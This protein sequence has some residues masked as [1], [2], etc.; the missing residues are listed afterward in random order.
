MFGIVVTFNYNLL[1]TAKLKNV[2]E[3]PESTRMIS[4]WLPANALI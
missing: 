1:A 4:A 3:L 2:W